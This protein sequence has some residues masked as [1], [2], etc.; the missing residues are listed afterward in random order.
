MKDVN[1]DIL[2]KVDTWAALVATFTEDQRKKFG[3]TS[4]HWMMQMPPVLMRTCL[5]RYLIELF[6]TNTGKFVIQERTGEITATHVDVECIYGLRNIGFSAMEIV[7]QEGEDWKSRIPEHFLCKS[8]GNLSIEKL[9]ADIKR[10]KASDDDF[11]RK[12]V[13]LL[14]GLVLVPSLPLTV[15]KKYYCLVED[16]PRI[17]KINWNDFTLGYLIANLKV[18]RRAGNMRQWPK[19]NLALLQVHI[20]FL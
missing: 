20:F 6:N 10:E 5:L 14:I 2:C 15:D 9:I 16:V 12:A 18:S 8:T 11:L 7:K 3:T 19:G 4:L 17:S 13:L 1:G